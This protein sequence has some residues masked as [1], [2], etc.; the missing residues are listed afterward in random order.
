MN[1]FLEQYL[2]AQASFGLSL[3][4]D[5]YGAK[6]TAEEKRVLGNLLLTLPARLRANVAVSAPAKK[7]I[8]GA[9]K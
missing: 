5:K 6:L 1:K 7:R 8:K 4:L 2:L 3:L 9:S